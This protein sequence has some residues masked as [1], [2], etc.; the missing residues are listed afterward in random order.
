MKRVVL[1]IHGVGTRG[2]WQ[3]KVA[4]LLCRHGFTPYL[5]DYG[6]FP[7]WRMAIPW[8]R[9]GRIDWLNREIDAVKNAED[10]ERPSAIAHSFGAYLLAQALRKY[11]HIRLGNVIFCGSI[12]DP[13][14]EWATL[15]DRG[16]LKSLRN[17]TGGRDLWAGLAKWLQWLIPD[18]GQSGVLGFTKRP[19]RVSNAPFEDY[20][21][22]DFFQPGHARDSWIPFLCG[23][24]LH[25]DDQKGIRNVL[26]ISSTIIAGKVGVARDNVRANV[27]ILDHL[28][29]ALYIPEGLAFRED[30]FHTNSLG[31]RELDIR[32][33]LGKGC[34][35][36]A[37]SERK[38]TT[39]V[40]QPGWST[41]PIPDDELRK[42]HPDLRWITSTPIPDLD[43]PLKFGLCGV[44]NVDCLNEVKTEAEMLIASNELK[45]I[46]EEVGQAL[47]K[48]F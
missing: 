46:A 10:I 13:E 19:R 32:I 31:E 4:P 5:L 30:R 23:V 17:E 16:Q 39:A 15:V 47:R 6:H 35:G 26:D 25:D 8:T 14:F 24:W 37:F 3:K 11:P 33:P 29:K 42:A 45:L 48:L 18:A 21:H 7:A 43:D 9:N 34:A 41:H 28:A 38:L 1:T 40:F 22:P 2:E 44:L 20:H 36:S 27:M 12:V